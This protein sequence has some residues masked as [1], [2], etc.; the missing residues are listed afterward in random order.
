M[1][2]ANKTFPATTG[3]LVYRTKNYIQTAD[4][5]I[6]YFIEDFYFLKRGDM[7]HAYFVAK[8]LGNLKIWDYIVDEAER[9]F[10]LTSKEKQSLYS[11]TTAR[12]IAAIP[13]AA[14]CNEPERTAIAHIVLYLSEIRG[15]Q[16]YCAHNTCDDADIFNR[17]KPISHFDGGDQKVIE[18]GMI[19]L[20]LIML[21]NHKNKAE[22]DKISGS[23]NPVATT[24][25]DY[26]RIE[27]ELIARLA[28][29]ENDFLDG[30]YFGSDENYP[31]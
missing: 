26:M 13:F 7:E 8:N 19:M 15:F 30:L 24:K 31:W 2:A 25:W 23:Y 6:E 17:L 18:H 4:Y 12:I 21:K 3:V 16:K 20:A 10:C 29:M 5:E 14:N 1:L 22:Q 27:R 28:V 11:S 9:V